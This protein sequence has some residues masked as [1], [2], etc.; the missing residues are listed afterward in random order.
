MDLRD[1]PFPLVHFRPWLDEQPLDDGDQ[2]MPLK[3]TTRVHTSPGR[4]GS[5]QLKPQHEF[6]QIKL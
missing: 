2:E 1:L 6:E 5:G 3:T 4:M